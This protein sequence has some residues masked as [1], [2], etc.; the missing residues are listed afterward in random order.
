M[1]EVAFDAADVLL[2]LT[3]VIQRGFVAF[4]GLY[5][6]LQVAHANVRHTCLEQHHVVHTQL[7]CNT[8]Y[9]IHIIYSIIYLIYIF[10]SNIVTVSLQTFRTHMAVFKQVEKQVL[11]VVLTVHD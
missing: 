4:L 7:L 11:A 3:K 2:N 5:E 1:A 6:H 10:I 8:I 9:T